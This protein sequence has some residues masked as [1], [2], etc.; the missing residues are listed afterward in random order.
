MMFWMAPVPVDPEPG[1]LG[2][3]VPVAFSRNAILAGTSAPMS[4]FVAC[5]NQV[6]LQLYR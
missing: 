1:L 5:P 4:I 6:V 3:A 2:G